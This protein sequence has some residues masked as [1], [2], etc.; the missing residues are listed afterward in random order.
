M[1]QRASV[2]DSSWR[3]DLPEVSTTTAAR[4]EL[5]AADGDEHVTHEYMVQIC[6]M[7]KK[8][9]T[10]RPLSVSVHLDQSRQRNGSHFSK[11]IAQ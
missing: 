3:P 10:Q 9:K 8:Q 6:P 7:K 4:E 5:R 2:V 1:S 11:V